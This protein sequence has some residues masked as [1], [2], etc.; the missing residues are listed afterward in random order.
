[1][2]TRDPQCDRFQVRLELANNVPSLLAHTFDVP[3]PQPAA[4]VPG[5]P[6]TRAAKLSELRFQGIVL[7]H[8]IVKQM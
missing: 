5:Q 6:D 1:M 4:L 3:P 7:V 8:A 2:T